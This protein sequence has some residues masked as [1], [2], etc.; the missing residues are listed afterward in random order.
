MARA[1]PLY[2]DRPQ[3]DGERRAQR[4]VASCIVGLHVLLL[5]WLLLSPQG[6][7]ALDSA[8]HLIVVELGDAPAR[9]A[10]KPYGMQLTADG[11]S[12]P[13]PARVRT[14]NPAGAPVRSP[15][16]VD[17]VHAA[18]AE[19]P[20]AA[21]PGAAVSA[22]G[23]AAD[24]TSRGM[25]AAGTHPRF[26][27]PKTLHSWLPPY[28]EDAFRGNH[29]GTV[30]LLVTI[31]SDGTLVAARVDRSSGNPSLDRAALESLDRFT[32]KAAERDGVAVRADAIVTINWIITQA[33]VQQ[34]ASPRIERIDPANLTHQRVQTQ[35]GSYLK[36]L[37]RERNNDADDRH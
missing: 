19:Q 3:I 21:I 5:L 20:G 25:G 35:Y 12:S 16:S 31:D 1:Y 14:A 10:A 17:P 6:K 34:F 30:D 13:P 23:N 15:T 32:F 7:R 9:P 27:P 37:Q 29:Q 22:P 33:I 2:F 28:P 8:S 36:A 24:Q 4:I 26:S 18:N 11:H